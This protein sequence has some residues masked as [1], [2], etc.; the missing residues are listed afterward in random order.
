MIITFDPT[1]GLPIDTSFVSGDLVDK[2]EI[3]YNTLDVPI[4]IGYHKAL[5]N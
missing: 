4:F 3:R 1:T 5:N 2:G